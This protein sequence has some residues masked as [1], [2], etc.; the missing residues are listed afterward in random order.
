MQA[1][2]GKAHVVKKPLS[3]RFITGIQLLQTRKKALESPPPKVHSCQIIHHVKG[4]AEAQPR[5][6]TLL[7]LQC[8]NKATTKIFEPILN[9]ALLN[10]V[11]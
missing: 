4:Q 6:T 1:N 7:I 11:Q 5:T 8:E 3:Q 10:S 9:Q 2:Q